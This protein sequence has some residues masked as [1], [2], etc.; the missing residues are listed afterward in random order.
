VASHESAS[1]RDSG[2]GNDKE[3]P[4]IAILAWDLYA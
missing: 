4:L 1:K 3:S 2:S